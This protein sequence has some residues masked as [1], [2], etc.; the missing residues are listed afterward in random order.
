[1]WTKRYFGQ[2]YMTS[3]RKFWAHLD[4]RIGFTDA[5]IHRPAGCGTFEPL[6]EKTFRSEGHELKAKAWAE[7]K[8][9]SL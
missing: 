1:M 2:S 4:A 6:M 7:K 5:A 9:K 8:L 3:Q